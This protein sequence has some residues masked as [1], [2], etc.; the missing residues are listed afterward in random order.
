[1]RQTDGS[2]PSSQFMVSWSGS[3]AEMEGSGGF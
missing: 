1:L 2:T 3:S